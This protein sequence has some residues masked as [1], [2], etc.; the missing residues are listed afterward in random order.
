VLSPLL[1]NL[2]IKDI[3]NTVP[4]N[5]KIIEFADDIAVLCQDKAVNRIYSSL[6][7]T[8]IN[9][10][11]DWLTNMRL[12]LS[13]TQFILFHRSKARVFPDEIRVRG[14]HYSETYLCQVS[15]HNDG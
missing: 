15:G 4:Y 13:I 3:I 14:G 6:R 8:F 11:N 1:F 10:M 5:C 2:Y 9:K 7:D 12:E